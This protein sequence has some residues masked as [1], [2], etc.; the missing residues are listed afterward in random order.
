MIVEPKKSE[1]LLVLFACHPNTSNVK[2][3]VKIMDEMFDIKKRH[4]PTDRFNFIAF[5]QNGPIFFEDF[6]FDYNY[7]TDTLKNIKDTLV[8]AN[9]A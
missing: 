7:I 2:K 9:I 5:Q 6:L 1:D 3:V 8:P 4:D